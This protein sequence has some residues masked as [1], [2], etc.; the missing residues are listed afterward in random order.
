MR[1]AWLARVY[2]SK[3]TGSSL[4]WSASSDFCGQVHMVQSRPPAH[5][6]IAKDRAT[7][8]FR[9]EILAPMMIMDD[10]SA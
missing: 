2:R 7:V 6:P 9:P 1:W 8:C 5:Y 10:C 4:V 3:A